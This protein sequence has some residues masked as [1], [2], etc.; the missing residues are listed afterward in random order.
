[1][2][3][4]HQENRRMDDSGYIKATIK[5]Y[6]VVYNLLKD[7]SD[8]RRKFNS[9]EDNKT[10]KA[11]RE[12]LGGESSGKVSLSLLAEKLG[13][14]KSV[15]SRRI[16]DLAKKKY[17]SKKNVGKSLQIKLLDEATMGRGTSRPRCP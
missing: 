13:K 15:A 11:I 17:L 1:M 9:H 8:Q 10:Y 14:D 2:R 5:D 7:L 16:S 3:C 12:I 4:F 6:R